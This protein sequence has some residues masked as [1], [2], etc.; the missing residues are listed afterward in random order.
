MSA[1]AAI[2]AQ[3]AEQAHVPQR[4]IIDTDLSRWWDDATAV[5]MA[6]VLQQR[7]EV[8]I[9]AVM[10]DIRNPVAAAAI[11][12]IDTAYGHST[13]PVGA[14][15]DSAANT[16]PHGYSDV[17]AQELPHTIRNSSQAQPAVDLY[18]RLLA[19]QPDHSVIVVAIGGDT[20]LAGL[21]RSGSGQGS[22]LPGR[23]LVA[24]KVEKLVIEDGLFPGGGPPFTNES[25]DVNA[26]K[27]L[28]STQGWPTT[29]AWVDGLTGINTKVGSG[30]C[31]A[32]PPKNPMRIVYTKLFNCGPPGDGDWDGPTLLYAV[33]GAAPDFSELGQ[34]GAAVINAEGGLSWGSGVGHP[35]EVYVHVVDQFDLNARIN[36]LI[37]SS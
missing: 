1:S 28:V 15:A 14:V 8:R 6:N 12:A 31:A 29:I 10:S 33:D 34:G 27:R 13:I 16:A 17:L 26:T 5:G 37:E 23:E 9:L 24:K 18:R 32:V 30:L 7:D 4:I 21:L 3:P 11:D 19:T 2:S 22:P 36:S 35:D 20:N 25:L